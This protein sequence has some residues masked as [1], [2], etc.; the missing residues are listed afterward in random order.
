[1]F[2]RLVYTTTILFCILVIVN[3]FEL[4]TYDKSRVQV[5]TIWFIVGICGVLIG[6]CIGGLLRYIP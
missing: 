3:L 2:E 1:M 5:F 6:L 4:D